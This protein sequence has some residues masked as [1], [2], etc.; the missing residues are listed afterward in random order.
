MQ[1]EIRFEP[2][3]TDS[4]LLCKRKRRSNIKRLTFFDSNKQFTFPPRARRNK[5]E[6]FCQPQ[7]RWDIP[8][9]HRAG[10]GLGLW[11]VSATGKRVFKHLR[12]W[13]S[14]LSFRWHRKTKESRNLCL[15]CTA[16]ANSVLLLSVERFGER[17]SENGASRGR[18]WDSCNLGYLLGWSTICS[19]AEEPFQHRLHLGLDCQRKS[20][21]CKKLVPRGFWRQI[22]CKT[23][24][25][26]FSN[27]ICRKF[28]SIQKFRQKK[29]RLRT[30]LNEFALLVKY[31]GPDCYRIFL[32][33]H[34]E[35]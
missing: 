31:C 3:S 9:V 11:G 14:N 18:I 4:P 2:R 30:T 15:L 27:N 16:V 21:T 26:I 22:G 29:E 8:F 20:S 1:R 23:I 12:V 10:Q 24:P 6:T 28:W 5:D 35:M 33:N 19:T 7:C 25:T 13:I 17:S 32:D 34:D